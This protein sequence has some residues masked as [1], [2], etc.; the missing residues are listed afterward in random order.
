LLIHFLE[1]EVEALGGKDREWVCQI[2]L[3]TPEIPVN[4][5]ITRNRVLP[6]TLLALSLLLDFL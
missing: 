5:R 6:E 4:S 2:P 1:V 3:E